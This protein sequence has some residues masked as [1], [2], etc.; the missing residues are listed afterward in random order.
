VSKTNWIVKVLSSSD[1]EKIQSIAKDS[2]PKVW[3]DKDFLYFLCHDSGWC[4][5]V[6][7]G[8]EL[9]SYLLSLVVR[10]DMDLVSIATAI[11]S[12]GKGLARKLLEEAQKDKSIQKIF[13]EVEVENVEAVKLYEKNGFKK[14]GKRLKYYENKRDALLMSWERAGSSP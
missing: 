8:E 5:G 12:R 10:G 1:V 11:A 14:S 2:F 13:L 9:R 3:S 6:F 4:R 7:E